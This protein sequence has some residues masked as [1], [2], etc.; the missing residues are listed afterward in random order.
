M[1]NPSAKIVNLSALPSPSVSSRTLIR[2]RPGPDDFRGYSRLS[3]TQTRPRSSNVMA[4]GFTRSG[5]L[6]TISTRNPSGTVIFLTASAGESGSP[7]G[8][9]WP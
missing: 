8:L 3:V 6:A 7:G 2:S 5:S 1:L 4:T 9:S